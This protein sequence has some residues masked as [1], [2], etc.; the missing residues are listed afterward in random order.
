MQ[1]EAGASLYRKFGIDP[2]NPDTLIVVDGDKAYRD[3]DAVLLIYEGLGWPWRAMTLFRLVPRFLRDPVYRF[4]ARNRYKIFGRRKTC[5][6][7]TT[8]EATRIL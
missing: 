2:A 4:I 3:S 6:M 5:W 1:G 7:P 8:E